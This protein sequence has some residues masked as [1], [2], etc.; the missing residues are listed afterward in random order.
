[1]KNILLLILFIIGTNASAQVCSTGIRG[2]KMERYARI[3]FGDTVV[4]G[5][6][7][8]AKDKIGMMFEFNGNDTGRIY[9]AISIRSK[10]LVLL[11]DSIDIKK[12]SLRIYLTNGDTINIFPNEKD[13]T[14]RHGVKR[15]NG[16]MMVF[17]NTYIDHYQLLKLDSARLDK[18]CFFKDA[19]T[20]ENMPLSSLEKREFK[21]AM[22]YILRR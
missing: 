9:V 6:P 4:M 14:Y 5:T 19:D 2:G 1:M 12:E 17:L 22:D 7:F 3:Q 10:S 11:K 18:V 21:Y 13:W 20:F 16:V 15:D 8:K